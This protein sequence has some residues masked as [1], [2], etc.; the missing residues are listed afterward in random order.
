MARSV[1]GKKAMEWTLGGTGP[2][3]TGLTS[4]RKREGD[5]RE[6][7]RGG[8]LRIAKCGR[9][10]EPLPSYSEALRRR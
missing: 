7:Q 4:C 5:G 2:P 9:G 10:V 1:T 6:W 3:Y 8:I